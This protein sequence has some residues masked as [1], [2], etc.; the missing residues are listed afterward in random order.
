MTRIAATM[1]RSLLL[2]LPLVT[3]S[4]VAGARPSDVPGWDAA[5]WSMDT[6]ALDTAFGD[7][8]P[9]LPARRDYGD[10]YAE[11]YLPDVALGDLRFRAFFQMNAAD[12]RLQQ[13][14]LE[15]HAAGLPAARFTETHDALTALYGEADT[16]CVTT[17]ATASATLSWRFP[18]TTIHLVFFDFVS[19]DI[20]Y[21]E[22]AP[23]PLRNPPPWAIDDD[24][25]LSGANA[26]TMPRRMLVRFHASDRADLAPP[27]CPQSGS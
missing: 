7:A 21:Q 18:T 27:G 6:A 15:P 14:L 17:G 20:I 1:V 25:P 10:A 16:R 26:R 23:N 3:I 9:P 12:G 22:K 24:P 19:P 11:R 13:V 2:A 5:R 4:A 8:L